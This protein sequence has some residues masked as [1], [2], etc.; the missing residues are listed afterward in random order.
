MRRRLRSLAVAADGRA[1][2]L[3][4]VALAHDAPENAP[5]QVGDGRLDDDTFF[6]FS[7]LALVGFLAAWKV[8]HFHELDE[9]AASR[10]R[11]GGGLLHARVGARRGGVEMTACRAA[12]RRRRR[13]ST[14]HYLQA[15]HQTDG[16]VKTWHVDWLS[17]AWLWG[18]VI[19]LVVVMLLWDL[20]VPH[21]AAA[22]RDLPGRQLRRV[23]DRDRPARRRVFFLVL[24]RVPDAVRGGADRRP[25][26]LG[27]EVLMSTSL[28]TTGA[29]PFVAYSTMSEAT[30]RMRR[31]ATSVRVAAGAQGTRSGVPGCQ[32]ID[33]FVRAEPDAVLVHC[34]T[35]WDTPG[36]SRRSSSAATRSSA[37]SRDVDEL[38][39]ERSLIMEKI[40]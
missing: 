35:T 24:D 23:H 4:A 29:P 17:L 40:F 37:C 15:H 8:G 26:R 33:V 19:V 31:L 21:D 39:P 1:A 38:E 2:V 9:Q 12:I 32:Q 18:F 14:T 10:S 28:A 30:S 13:S 5:V 3:P 34:Y 20:A 25:P 7:G 27:A 16:P 11:R 6:I 22:S 36:S